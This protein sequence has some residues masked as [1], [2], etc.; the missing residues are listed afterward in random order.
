MLL[1]CRLLLPLLVRVFVLL[2]L[3]LL[4]LSPL[5][6]F[7]AARW[8]IGGECGEQVAEGAGEGVV[9]CRRRRHGYTGPAGSESPGAPAHTHTNRPATTFS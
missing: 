6:C 1:L 7:I 4:L 5:L 3:L 9:S 2:L 8:G